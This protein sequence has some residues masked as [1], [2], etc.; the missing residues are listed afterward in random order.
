[1]ELRAKNLRVRKIS[2]I[3][4]SIGSNLIQPG[5]TQTS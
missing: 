3:T 1:M 4:M 5:T 2:E